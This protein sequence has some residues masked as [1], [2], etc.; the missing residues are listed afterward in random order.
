MVIDILLGQK[1]SD[2]L[3]KWANSIVTIF[4]N[5]SLSFGDILFYG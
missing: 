1:N 2:N 5:L 3:K 4:K